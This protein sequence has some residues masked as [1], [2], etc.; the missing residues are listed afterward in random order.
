MSGRRSS[1]P[2]VW[3]AWACVN[4][5]PSMDFTSAS[6]N[7]ARRSGEVSTSTVVRRPA[8]SIGSTNSERRRRRFFG[9]FGSQAPQPW[10]TRGTPAEEP[11][12][13]IVNVSGMLGPRHFGEAAEEV[14]RSELGDML[15]RDATRLR[16]HAGGF[17]DVGRLVALAA[18]RLGREIG[19]VGFDQDPILGQFS[20]NPAQVLAFLE[21]PGAGEGYIVADGG[22]AG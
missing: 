2:C 18:P 13:R 20:S 12:P 16:E 8:S 22:P 21:G 5:T 1:M 4:R 3:S 15:G 10:P 7:C 11:Q 17:G 14:R 6:S 9:F 19:R